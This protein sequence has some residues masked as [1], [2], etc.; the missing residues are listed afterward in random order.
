VV[1]V[2]APPQHL[3]ESYNCWL[4]NNHWHKRLQSTWQKRLHSNWQKFSLPLC[5]VPP[6]DRT[7]ICKPSHPRDHNAL[8]SWKSETGRCGVSRS[9]YAWMQGRGWAPP[10]RAL[11]A[12]GCWRPRTP[13]TAEEPCTTPHGSPVSPH[14]EPMWEHVGRQVAQRQHACFMQQAI[15]HNMSRRCRKQRTKQFEAMWI[16]CRFHVIPDGAMRWG[17]ALT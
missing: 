2:P 13:Q 9:R 6:I 11:W 14:V 3:A 16:P 17:R 5:A 10:P 15:R 4:S 1:P 12:F 8:P 7:T